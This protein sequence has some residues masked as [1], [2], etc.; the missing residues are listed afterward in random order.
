M[1]KRYLFV[2]LASV[3]CFQVFA[4]NKKGDKLFKYYN[5]AEAI[6]Y[7]LKAY[8]KGNITEQNHA[9]Q[10]LAD[11][12]RL[13]NNAP[14]ARQ[15]YKKAV[16][17]DTTISINWFYLGQSL[18]SLGLYDEAANAFST[19]NRQVPDDELGQRYYQYCV[20]I[21][22]WLSLPPMAEIKNIEELNS[23]YA[24]FC[25]V[26]YRDG[27]VF[28]SDRKEN[29]SDKINTYG[30][31]EFSYLNLFCT[32]P[33]YYKVFWNG[34]PEPKKMSTS[35]NQNYHDGPACFS[36]DY[37]M[38]YITR[39]VAKKGKKLDGNIK[40]HLLKIYYAEIDD[41]K[42]L[43]YKAFAFNSDDYSVGHPALSEDGQQII[44]SSDMPGGMGGSDLYMCTM[45]DG[46]WGE[47]V[48]LGE[49]I[50]S[51]EDEVFPYWVND[52]VLF[53]SSDGHL[54][55]GGLDIFQANFE[56]DAWRKPENLKSPL[57][58]SYDDFGIV[59]KDNLKEGMFSS[60]RPEGKGNDDIYGFKNL[61]RINV[62]S[63]PVLQISGRVVDQSNMPLEGATVFLLDP[64]TS[65]VKVLITDKNGV[66]SDEA[67]YN[68]NYVPKAMKDSYMDDCLTFRTPEGEMESYKVPHDLVLT[69]LEVDQVFKVENIYYDLDKWYIRK[70]AEAPLDNLV[71]LMKKYPITAELSSH[72]DCRASD[73]YNRELSQK[74]AE[75]AVRYIILQGIAPSRI[76][77][78]GY[79]ESQLVN[80][81]A[82]G[83]DCKEEEH[84]ANRRTEF[85]ITSVGS[86]ADG[87][88]IDLSIYKHG[89]IV[90]ANILGSQFFTD[91]MK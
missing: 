85:K 32:I 29:L 75:S 5:Y 40:T 74:R 45:K 34:L 63:E 3:L 36:S 90:P 77:A 65:Q 56:K 13:T 55:Y 80:K 22:P 57:N 60:N 28:T 70:D 6:P 23:K 44:F 68:Q 4:Q 8:N 86:R 17:L 47:P 26:F 35:F 87:Y 10:K 24:D 30:W 33:Q 64:I 46:T 49:T 58:S 89:D 25:P 76:T 54:G 2:F 78:K 48:N 19:F 16:M 15:W 20:D 1:K 21:E 38:V 39:T 82:D 50:N 81:C 12:Y 71:A 72:T 62:V 88:G 83:V 53:F 73:E 91:C 9:I 7:Y 66:Y 43:D 52:S 27:I 59:L 41:D 84:Q 14:K 79:G 51:E 11:C 69:K 31:T 18:R 37:R 42:H 61:E 67:D